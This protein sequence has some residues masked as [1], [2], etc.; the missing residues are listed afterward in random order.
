MTI[1]KKHFRKVG[2][3]RVLIKKH[4]RKTKRR[5]N[6]GAGPVGEQVS[7]FADKFI[8]IKGRGPVTISDIEEGR[9]ISKGDIDEINANA[10]RVARR[11]NFVASPKPIR[12]TPSGSSFGVE[13]PFEA[14]QEEINFV[15][16]QMGDEIQN[17]PAGEV[18]QSIEERRELM[19]NPLRASLIRKPDIDDQIASAER[20]QRKLEEDQE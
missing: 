3:R 15:E 19:G 18:R 10:I 1:V 7:K 2:R 9:A 14:T 13:R 20:K 4:R 8:K 11:K 12:L 16:D 6:F 5:K 17:I